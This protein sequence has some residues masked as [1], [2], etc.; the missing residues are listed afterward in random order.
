MYSLNPSITP[1]VGLIVR[2]LLYLITLGL[3]DLKEEN[4]PFFIL[5]IVPFVV[6][7]SA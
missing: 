7:P 5:I 6:P 4:E 3:T 1:E 2:L